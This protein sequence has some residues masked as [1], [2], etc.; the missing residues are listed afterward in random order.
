MKDDFFDFEKENMQII[1]YIQ[2]SSIG[3]IEQFLRLKRLW[4]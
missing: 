1:K 2:Q 3:S 4:K